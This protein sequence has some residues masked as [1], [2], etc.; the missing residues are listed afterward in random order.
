MLAG[1]DRSCRPV[2]YEGVR[3]RPTAEVFGFNYDGSWGVSGLDVW[4]HH[5]HGRMSVEVARGKRYFPEWNTA[6]W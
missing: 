6:R 1:G 2:G 4:Q 5:D 3:V